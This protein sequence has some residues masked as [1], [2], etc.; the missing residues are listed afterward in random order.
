VGPPKPPSP[1]PE[2]IEEEASPVKVAAY[3]DDSSAAPDPYA[4]ER[5]RLRADL[6]KVRG[7]VH[8]IA[9]PQLAAEACGV[10]SKESHQAATI[11]VEASIR[12]I[13]G[14]LECSCGPIV[15]RRRR[16]KRRI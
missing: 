12:V 4:Q 14:T 10:D 16:K 5:S 15:C 3:N 6:Q 2:G 13:S 8:V 9:K 11:I 1:V 7:A